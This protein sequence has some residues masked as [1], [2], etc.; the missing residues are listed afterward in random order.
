M[1]TLG[2]RSLSGLSTLVALSLPENRHSART[3][4]LDRLSVV[5]GSTCQL[6]TAASPVAFWLHLVAGC[7]PR[8]LVQTCLKWHLSPLLAPVLSLVAEADRLSL[9]CP[10]VALLRLARFDLLAI[11]ALLTFVALALALSIR[12]V[13]RIRVPRLLVGPWPIAAVAQGVILVLLEAA[14]LR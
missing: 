5:G 8:H 10:R 2:P 1:A 6:S 11:V 4:L 9:Q 3:V 14:R 7:L 12:T 13:G